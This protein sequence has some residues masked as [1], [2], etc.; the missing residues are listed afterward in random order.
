MLTYFVQYTTIGAIYNFL[1]F[2]NAMLICRLLLLT[3]FEFIDLLISTN[4]SLLCLKCMY[5]KADDGKCITMGS[6]RVSGRIA[7]YG[8]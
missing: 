8:R 7:C 6:Q 5:I 2:E 4:L 1:Y 3:A